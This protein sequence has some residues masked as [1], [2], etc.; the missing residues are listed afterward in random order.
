MA[1]PDGVAGLQI[2]ADVVAWCARQSPP[3][4]IADVVVQD[5]FTHDVVV[6]APASPPGWLVFDTT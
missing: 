4:R 2:L 5:E 3:A 1:L 6:H